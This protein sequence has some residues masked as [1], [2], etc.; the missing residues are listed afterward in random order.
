M[1]EDIDPITP[2]YQKEGEN[3]AAKVPEI[4]N[5]SDLEKDIEF[6]EEP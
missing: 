4:S 2:S 3:Y 5:L 1:F 6:T